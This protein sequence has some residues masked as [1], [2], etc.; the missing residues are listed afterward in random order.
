MLSGIPFLNIYLFCFILLL[1]V[2]QCICRIRGQLV[3]IGSLLPSC[4]SLGWDSGHQ[5]WQFAIRYLVPP[6]VAPR[7]R[8]QL[9]YMCWD[10]AVVLCT[11][12][13]PLSGC[14]DGVHWTG[15]LKQSLEAMGSVWYWLGMSGQR[16]EVGG[17]GTTSKILSWCYSSFR[18]RLKAISNDLQWNSSLRWF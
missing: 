6:A 14:P 13:S 10:P 4:E 2:P 12:L 9:W 15:R 1:C 7:S 16:V 18:W 5:G 3:V 17:V 8:Y 11:L